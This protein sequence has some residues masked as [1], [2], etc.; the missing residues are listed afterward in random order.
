MVEAR[1]S[2]LRALAGPPVRDERPDVEILET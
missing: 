2:A 1:E